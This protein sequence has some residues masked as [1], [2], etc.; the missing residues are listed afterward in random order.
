MSDS[1]YHGGF[2]VA[3]EERYWVAT[4]IDTGIASHGDDPNDAIDRA[5]EAVELAQSDPEP[6]PE[7]EQDEI[8]HEFGIDVTDDERGI[9]SPNGMP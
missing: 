1:L 6:A 4:H 7:E 8:R 9:E 3:R 5:I 2:T